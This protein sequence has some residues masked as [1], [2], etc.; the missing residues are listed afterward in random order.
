VLGGRCGKER[1]PLRTVRVKMERFSSSEV[2]RYLREDYPGDT[3][4]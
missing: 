4:P 1:V 2:T 3:I